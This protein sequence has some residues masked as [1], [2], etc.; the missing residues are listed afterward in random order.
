MGK[1]THRPIGP[2]ARRMRLGR[3]RPRLGAAI[4]ALLAAAGMW[5]TTTAS[6][7]TV[8]NE[9]VANHTGPDTFEFIEVFSDQVNADLS[10][11]TLLEIEG[12]AGA[13]LGRVDEAFTVGTTDSA[14]LWSTGF[15]D[16]ALE[17]G[18][19]SFLVVEAFTGM[20]GDALDDDGDGVFDVTPWSALLDSIAVSDGGESDRTYGGVALGPG[21]DG[22]SQTPGGASRIPNGVDTD[23]PGDW[24]RNDFGGA[25]LPGFDDPPAPSTVRNSPGEINEAPAP[26]PDAVINEFVANHRGADTAEFIELSSEPNAALTGLTV[27]EIEGDGGA[28]AGV[29]DGVFQAGETNADGLW[30]TEFLSNALENGTLTLLL[31]EQFSGSLGDDL[32]NDDDGVLDLTPWLNLRD[33]VAVTDGDEIDRTYAATVLDDLGGASRI[34][35]GVDTD[36]PGDW[37]V[38]DFDGQGLPGFD[39]GTLET[40]EALNTP[41]AINSADA[42]PIPGDFDGDGDVDAFDL[43]IWQ[44]GFGTASGATA[45]DGD[46]DGDG[47]VDAFDLGLWQTNFGTGVT[48]VVPEPG[49]GVWLGVAFALAGARRR[50]RASAIVWARWGS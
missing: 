44:T 37:L 49:A 31:V 22:I 16:G 24:R 28:N 46:A 30:S 7:V 48:A 40:G 17:N 14:G 32:D 26:P 18:T 43:G 15:L 39:E 42:A 9:F 27:L 25:G 12:D 19:K 8:I 2:A 47:D 33:A 41:G 20:V 5:Y 34:P 50:G 10:G 6:A 11:L 13:S 35:N 1:G 38:N 21:F 36:S 29:I 4:T 23:T 3:T 45:A